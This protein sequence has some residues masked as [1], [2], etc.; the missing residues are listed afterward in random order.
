L[1]QE[2]DCGMEMVRV[3]RMRF[4]VEREG[5]WMFLNSPSVNEGSPEIVSGGFFKSPHFAVV[6]GLGDW[7]ET[8]SQVDRLIIAGD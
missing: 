7:M 8:R 6:F 5:N 4:C 3:D 2:V 1:S